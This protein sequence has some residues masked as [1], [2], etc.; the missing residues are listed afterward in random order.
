MSPR[1]LGNKRSSNATV[2][3][4]AVLAIVVAGAGGCGFVFSQGPPAAHERQLYIDCG[5]SI[6]PPVVDT[7]AAWLFG[8]TTVTAAGASGDQIR[9]IDKSTAVGVYSGLTVL[10]AASAMYGYE[11]SSTCRAA[12]AERAADWRRA[13]SFFAQ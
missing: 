11:A 8:L 13:Q 10:L 6:A 7:V 3:I 9:G 12:K 4:A 2:A 1:P 5:E